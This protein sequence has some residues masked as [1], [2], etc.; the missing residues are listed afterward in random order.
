MAMMMMTFG[1]LQFFLGLLWN[2]QRYKTTKR[3]SS[4]YRTMTYL[5]VAQIL[6]SVLFLVVEA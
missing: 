1:S 4:K 3:Y 2:R 5:G 6:I